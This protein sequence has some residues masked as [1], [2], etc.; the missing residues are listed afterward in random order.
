MSR[1]QKGVFHLFLPLVLLC[2]H[3]C[4]NSAPLQCQFSRISH[5]CILMHACPVTAVTCM[6]LVQA[7]HD[8]P[9][10]FSCCLSLSLSLSQTTGATR[11]PLSQCGISFCALLSPVVYLSE[12]LQ[13]QIAS[14]ELYLSRSRC[15]PLP[16]HLNCPAVA[17]LPEAIFFFPCVTSFSPSNFANDQFKTSRTQLI[18]TGISWAYLIF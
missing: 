11:S 18:V 2:F 13:L 12:G 16:Y 6:C 10:L 15:L 1:S 9:P 5:L 7:P 17:H 8:T 14:V 3:L 4:C